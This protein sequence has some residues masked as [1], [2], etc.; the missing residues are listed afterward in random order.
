M[1]E[2]ELQGAN[3][4]DMILMVSRGEGVPELVQE[5]LMA[6]RPLRALVAMGG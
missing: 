2:P 6:V 1:A 3:V 5:P 4:A